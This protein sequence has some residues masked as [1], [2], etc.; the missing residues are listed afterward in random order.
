MT[1]QK[2]L[3][4]T[5]PSPDCGHPD[6]CERKEWVYFDEDEIDDLEP[7]EPPGEWR[8]YCGWC[9]DIELRIAAEREAA[10]ADMRTRQAALIIKGGTVDI[11]CPQIGILTIYGGAVGTRLPDGELA[12]GYYESKSNAT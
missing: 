12:V 8:E 11:A 3:I 4:R 10:E 2:R 7:G 5:D 1:A 6:G 9:R